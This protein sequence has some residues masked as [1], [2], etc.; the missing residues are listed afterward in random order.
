MKG[1]FLMSV[2]SQADKRQQQ[3]QQQ[4]A[5]QH[6]LAAFPMSLGVHLEVFCARAQYMPVHC[7]DSRKW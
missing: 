5:P 3:Q 1:A 7:S 6:V 2:S 4:Q